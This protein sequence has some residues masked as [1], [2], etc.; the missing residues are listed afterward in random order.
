MDRAD[1]LVV[2]GGIVG[3]ATARAVLRSHPGLALT[4]VEKEASVGFH[5]SGRNSGV[6]H[7]GVYYAPGSAKARLCHAGR[8][9]M[10]EYCRDNGI[11]HV[12]CGKLVVATD[13]LERERLVELERRCAANGVRAELLAPAALREREPHVAGVAALH[14]LDTGIVDYAAVCRS[15]AAEIH[16]TGRDDQTRVRGRV[17]GGRSDR[18]GGR[19]DA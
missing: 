2:G 13:A 9:S 6:I 7:A 11:D 8:A 14:V 19:D 18:P 1:V 15:L 16:G 3:L 4:L 10:I 17:G 5:Q 12:V